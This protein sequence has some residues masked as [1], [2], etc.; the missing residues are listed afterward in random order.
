MAA[1]LVVLMTSPAFGQDLR[2]SAQRAASAALQQQQADKPRQIP[3]GFL[4][5]GIGLL[6]AGGLYLGLGAAE[7][8]EAETCVYTD[9]FSPSC[10]SNRKVLLTTGAVLAGAGGVLLAIGIKKSHA[11]QVTFVPRGVSVRQSVPLDLGL[12]RLFR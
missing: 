8:A 2:S 5:T 11:P 4:W 6:G 9:D 10:V 12:G 1:V 3:P 7:E